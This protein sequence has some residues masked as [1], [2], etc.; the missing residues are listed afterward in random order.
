MDDDLEGLG[1]DMDDDLAVIRTDFQTKY[2]QQTKTA[3]F[4]MT[5]L[6]VQDKIQTLKM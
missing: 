4:G 2:N 3:K 5:Q 6:G 1:S